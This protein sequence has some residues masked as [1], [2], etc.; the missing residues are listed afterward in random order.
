MPNPFDAARSEIARFLAARAPFDSLTPEEL[1]EVVA[2][3]ELEFHPAGDAIL[4]EDGG[5]VTYLRVI[6][7]GAVDISHA[8]KLLD[9]LGPGDAFG[10]AAMLS[11]LPPGF[12]ARAS[13]DTLC[14]RLPVAAARP[15]LERARTRELELSFQASS[16]E[17]VARLIRSPTVVSDPQETVGD[18]ARRMTECG[19]SSAIVE[20]GRGRLGILTDR[21]IRTKIVAGGMPLSA[22]VSSAMT[23]PVFTVSPDSLGR[24]VLFELLEHGIRH[25]VV[26][27]EDSRIVGVVE[28]AD[29][30]AAHPRSWFGI[31]RQIARA[32]DVE[33]LVDVAGRLSQIVFELHSSNLRASEVARVLSALMDALVVRVLELSDPTRELGA[34]G[35]I[36]VALGSQARREMTPASIPRGAL[37][38]S[39]QPPE[40]W[41]GAVAETLARCGLS[42]EVVA[43]APGEWAGADYDD[44]LVLTV[45]IERRPLWGTPREPLPVLEGPARERAVQALARRALSVRPPTGFDGDAVLQLDGTRSSHLDIRRAAVIPIVELGRWAGAAAGL[46]QGSTPERLQAAAADGVIGQSDADT[47][48]EAFELA[49]E[50]RVAHHMQQLAA[51]R[52]PDDRIEPRAVSPL[53]RDHLRD[54]F[55]AVAGVQRGLAA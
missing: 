41:R 16:D 9:L 5:P 30:F 34:N 36:W 28:D 17:P 20:L 43:H 32:Q 1:G 22:P 21:D 54:V 37:V 53:T 46:T 35:T 38:C 50:L 40:G 44:E 39:E 2:E 11:G 19:A 23:T 15:L 10:H 4:T 18:V 8:G 42:D 27:D 52:R 13:E 24:D 6:H 33:A 12:E 25:A 26:L 14:Y 51:G 45:L 55:R 48:T 47:L 31:R 49:L 29:L 3:T 7:S